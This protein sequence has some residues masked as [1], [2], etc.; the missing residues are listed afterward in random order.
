M[1]AKMRADMMIGNSVI[2]FISAF[3]DASFDVLCDLNTMVSFVSVFAFAHLP[4]MFLHACVYRTA[5]DSA[6][7]FSCHLLMSGAA[8]LAYPDTWTRTDG[9]C[10]RMNIYHMTYVLIW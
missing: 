1:T 5:L 8:S 4:P 9:V 6:P 3:M 2:P 10:S 7:D